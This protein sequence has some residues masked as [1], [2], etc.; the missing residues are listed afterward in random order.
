MERIK[1][2]RLQK[3]KEQEYLDRYPKF[4]NIKKFKEIC[5]KA[6]MFDCLNNGVAVYDANSGTLIDRYISQSEV[7]KELKISPVQVFLYVN[8]KSKSRRYFM[9]FEPYYT[10]EDWYKDESEN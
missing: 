7:A 5:W 3:K 8:G 4:K 2:L 1:D 6:S 9:K 10:Y